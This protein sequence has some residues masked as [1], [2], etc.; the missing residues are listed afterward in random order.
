[1]LHSLREQIRLHATAR[2]TATA[3]DLG[4]RLEVCWLRVKHA[5][6]QSPVAYFD[7]IR[8]MGLAHLQIATHDTDGA[9][10][11]L[12]AA[13]KLAVQLNQQRDLLEARVLQAVAADRGDCAADEALR[14]V[15]SIAESNGIARL[16]A[17]THPAAVERVRMLGGGRKPAA[18]GGHA[19]SYAFAASLTEDGG[20]RNPLVRPPAFAGTTASHLAKGAAQALFTSK[21]AS[22]LAYLAQGMSNKE[23]A[24][25]LDLGPETVKWHLKNVFA[26]LNAGSRRHA[27]DR[28]R[29]L[30]LL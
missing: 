17:D 2:R 21:E 5:A 28:A 9:R 16:F 30:G 29:M 18:L 23:I 20:T 6:G 13:A 10:T 12:A 14:E 24:R 11:T 3:V 25:A 22:T 27:V 15:L 19:G 8:R 26:K 7:L 4:E 1:M